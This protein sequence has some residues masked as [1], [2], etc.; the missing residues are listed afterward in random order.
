MASSTPSNPSVSGR[1]DRC[2]RLEPIY[3]TKYD[4]YKVPSADLPDD[5]SLYANNEPLHD[6]RPI[7]I[8][9]IPSK[10]ILSGASKRPRTNWTWQLGYNLTNTSKTSNQGVWACKLCTSN[11][12]RN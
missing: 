10:H 6:D 12:L 9:R 4:P 2:K 3:N 1:R 8:S 7:I 5:Y 11:C